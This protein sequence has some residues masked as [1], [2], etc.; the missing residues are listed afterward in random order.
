M[1]ILWFSWKDTSHPQAGGA[2]TVSSQIISRLIRDGHSV[3]LITSRYPGSGD[4]TSNQG[5][6]TYYVGTR[7]TVYLHAWLL[8]RKKFVGW[9]DMVV[10]EMNTIPFLAGAYT[11]TP[12]RFLLA[13]QLARNVWFYQMTF[14]FSIVGYLLEPFLL[15]IA[16]KLYPHTLTESKSSK[17]DMKRFGFKDTNVFRVGMELPPLQKLEMKTDRNLILS[18]GAVRPMKRTLHAVKAFEYAKDSNDKLRM[19]VAGDISSPYGLKVQKYINESRHK[20]AIE[21][22]GR[23]SKQEK[24]SLMRRAGIIIVTSIKEGWGLIVTEANSQGTPA[25]VYDTDGLRDSVQ[26]TITGIVSRN[27]DPIS[28]GSEINN[29]VNHGEQ[30]EK[31]RHAAWEWSK[32]FTFENSYTD[33][34]K[35]TKVK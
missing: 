19:V 26:H 14:P 23:V 12:N 16:S 34:L 35:I 31:I 22:M 18:L 4:H 7:Y 8:Y 3:R 27:G 1:N 17:I 13:Y 11:K 30:Y 25:I 9:E 5:L 29:L 2:E 10:D 21:I 24:L 33:F 6:E 28:M 32:E 20:H 15:L